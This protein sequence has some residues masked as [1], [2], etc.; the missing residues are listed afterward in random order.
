MREVTI[1]DVEK[2]LSTQI[3]E[4]TEETSETST[5]Q[6]EAPKNDA[7]QYIGT[8]LQHKIGGYG[9]TDREE[10]QK[11]VAEKKLTRIGE[12]IG[13][14][15]EFR[16][17]WMDVEKGL[18]GERA[19]Y[20]PEDWEFK[21]R[22]ATV[23]AIRNW[24]TIDEENPNSVDDVFNE[25]LKSCLSIVTPSGPLPWG[26]IRSWDRFFFILLIREYSM[27]NGEKK[28][29]FFEDC[30][31][32]ENP[33]KFTL[34][35]QSLLYE[36]PDP[37]VMKYYSPEEQTWMIDP[38]E[39]GV[40]WPEPIVLYLPTLEKDANIK[41]W[42]IDRVQT[43]KKVDQVFI[44]F[45]PWLAPKISKD[46]TIAQR[47]IREYEVKFKSWDTEMFGFM[48]EVINNITVIPSSKL[49]ETCPVCGE[50]VTAQ[51]T[52][53]DGIRTLFDMAGGRKKFG[54]K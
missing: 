9:E 26:N 16:E 23:E 37:E 20:Y 48:D 53:Q 31:N 52:F 13:Q 40:D 25:I 7:A 45:L 43:N 49:I 34:N 21:I 1:D 4:Y 41:A 36:F 22:P 12:K 50:E 15:V 5:V 44:K 6:E 18:L 51:I 19:I 2:T 39:Y 24:S 28:V 3:D 8:K 30:P 10:D 14:S 27:I 54:S 29:E 17:G 38:R 47:Q 35:S 33:V 46:L 32:C 42:L 11:M